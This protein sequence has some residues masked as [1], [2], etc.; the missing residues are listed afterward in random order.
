MSA[1]ILPF[2]RQTE[3]GFWV[4]SATAG[5]FHSHEAAWR[6]IDSHT[7]TGRADIDIYNRIRIAFSK[8]GAQ[9]PP[10]GFRHHNERPKR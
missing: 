3:R 9:P 5:P 2:V 6:W 1:R 8:C 7:D 4:V 10:D